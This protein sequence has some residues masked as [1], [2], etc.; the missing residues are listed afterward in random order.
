MTDVAT[1]PPPPTPP[2][3]ALDDLYEAPQLASK[4][5]VGGDG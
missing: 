3:D 1:G 2:E 5:L 4:M